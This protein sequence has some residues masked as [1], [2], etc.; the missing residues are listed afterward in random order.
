MKKRITRR[1]VEA[2]KPGET[3]WDDRV[4]G[5]AA[6][7]QQK[8]TTYIIKAR[9]KGRQKLL[10]IGRH[11]SP[12]TPETARKEARRLLVLLEQGIDPLEEKRRERAKRTLDELWRVFVEDHVSKLKP[13]S[14]RD[15][16]YRYHRYISPILGRKPLADITR[17]DVIALHRKL[18]H[19]PRTA[20]FCL[21]ILSKLMNWAETKGFRPQFSN[22]VRGIR[23][24]PENHRERFLTAEELQRLG[25]ALDEE[26][27]E[28]G[29][30]FA[31]AAIRLLILTGARL[32]EITSL[33]W[34]YVDLDRGLL[35]LPDS[36][37]GK[38]A[39]VLNAAARQVL[40]E[41]PR[42]HGNPHVICGHKEGQP[43]V[44][45]HKPWGRIRKRAGIEDVR[46]H[47]L[48]HTFA[49]LA[50][51]QGG[52]L[53]RIGALLGHSQMQTTQRY[54]HLIVDDVRQ[55]AETVGDELADMVLGS[56]RS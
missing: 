22:P 51:R 37:T 3:I 32:G 28:H 31:V 35:L 9:L 49:S 54:A 34:E 33:R 21:S 56:N 44:N 29:D 38:K 47:D 43:L 8:A 39:I 12:W 36:K 16:E 52:S 15:Y 5:F 50:A 41:L 1:A 23:K 10:T 4:I 6:R 42:L 48:R 7:R 45:L 30:I 17:E 13:R 25:Q 20:N 18:Q 24:Y 27:R 2:L 14:Q 11:G 19:I 26:L 46:I 55:L 40:E 53:P